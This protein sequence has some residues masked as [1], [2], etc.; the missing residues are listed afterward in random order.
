MGSEFSYRVH[1]A[2]EGGGYLLQLAEDA[3]VCSWHTCCIDG[4]AGWHQLPVLW[5]GFGHCSSVLS[6][7]PGSW[8]Y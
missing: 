1:F 2:G 6:V 8:P 4:V 5:G 3:R 7:K